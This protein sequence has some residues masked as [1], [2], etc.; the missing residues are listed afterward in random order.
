MP[1][2]NEGLTT[3][4]DG[5]IDPNSN[6]GFMAAVAR[7]VGA[8]VDAGELERIESRNTRIADGLTFEGSD[9]PRDEKGR[10]APAAPSSVEETAAPTTSDQGAADP[11]LAAYL[12]RTGGD[13]MAALAAAVREAKEA[14]SLIG[15]QGND[16]GEERRARQELAERLARLEGRMEAQPQQRLP[17]ASAEDVSAAQEYVALHGGNAAMRYIL[18]DQIN[19]P[20]LIEH[21]LEA[22]KSEDPVEAA[23]WNARYQTNLAIQEAEAR[24]QQEQPAPAA[25]QQADPSRALLDT[26]EQVKSTIPANEWLAVREHLA[27]LLDDPA[28]PDAV[29]NAV[30]SDDGD[31]RTE[32]VTALVKLA[33]RR[34]IA[35][36]VDGEQQQ[37]TDRTRQAKAAAGLATGSL[38]PVQES[39]GKTEEQTREERISA[40]HQRLLGTETTSVR[41][42]LTY[43]KS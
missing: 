1:E 18:S 31:I 21:V 4:D 15:R 40:F 3:G 37:H 32:G 34:V 8:D 20:D 12:D 24:R 28:T 33:R 25:Q 30:V 22:W 43:G 16:L 26:L 42:G 27:P 17:I 9:Q 29:K 7:Q 11:D 35:A 38:R 23:G 5:A 36:A 2:I 39:A 41:D 13:P 10:F 19:R 14:Q 6:A